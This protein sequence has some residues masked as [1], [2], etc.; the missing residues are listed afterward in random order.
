MVKDEGVC[1]CGTCDTKPAIFLKRNSLEP[2]LLHCLCKLIYGLSIDDKSDNPGWPLAYL[3]RD[4]IWPQQVS[5]TFCRST[6]K[7]G[8][9]RGLVNKKL[10][11]EF[12]ELWSGGPMISC[13]DEQ[14]T[15][16]DALV[17]WF[18]NNFPMFADNFRVVSI[19]YVA[20][21]LG[22]SFLYKCPA[23][24]VRSSL[25]QHGLLV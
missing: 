14:Q 12:C 5:R 15:C 10:F 13:A 7:F 20:Q 18:F 9:I 8:S 6:T 3:S 11:S 1:I 25:T 19:H 21:G 24:R 22:G 17:K 4:K 16:T 2:K 23:L